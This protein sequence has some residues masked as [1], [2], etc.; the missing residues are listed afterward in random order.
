[1]LHTRGTR[2]GTVTH[3]ASLSHEGKVII[4]A[5]VEGD[6][7]RSLEYT[8]RQDGFEDSALARSAQAG[9]RTGWE[10]LKTLALP[11]ERDD[12]SVLGREAKT[13]RDPA[14][15]TYLMRSHYDT[16]QATAD[17][18]VQLVSHDGHVYVFRQSTSHQLLVDRF[19]LDG[20]T[21]TLTPK[22]EVRYKRSRQRYAPAEDMKIGGTGKEQRLDGADSFDFRDVEGKPFFEPTMVVCERFVGSVDLGRFAVIVTPTAEPGTFRWHF[23]WPSGA[24]TMTLLSIRSG[25]TQIFD[26][27]DQRF[28]WTDPLT[29]QAKTEH[30]PGVI[31][32]TI[33]LRAEGSA[34]AIIGAPALV[35]YDVQHEAETDAG[36]QFVRDASK[37]LLTVPTD[38]GVAAL[39]FAIGLDGTLAQ[40]GPQVITP[41]IAEPRAVA[42]PNDVLDTVRA[43][44][45]GQSVPAGGIAQMSRSEDADTLDRVRVF[46]ASGSPLDQL[47]VGDIV[48]I[49]DTA[50]YNGLHTVLAIRNVNGVRPSSSTRPSP[51]TNWGTGRRSSMCA[52]ERCSTDC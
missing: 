18:A 7:G 30:V 44:A 40:I 48:R 1:M 32:R 16:A 36:V 12:P 11:A 25:V 37:V 39:S 47:G 43:L 15:G 38:R 51:A 28:R 21:N 42:L 13:L 35:T 29:G 45:A 34:L 27:T 3:V 23:A 33:D 9:P 5:T 20:M 52:P 19:V 31:V 22:L 41:I 14:H 17:A 46:A 2:T 10:E 6:A 24:S 26:V 50:A 49:A 8:V 4:V